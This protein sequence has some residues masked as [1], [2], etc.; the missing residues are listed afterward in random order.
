MLNLPVWSVV[1]VPN[2]VVVC[3]EESIASTLSPVLAVFELL[4]RTC[5]VTIDV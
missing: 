2:G 1:A 3:R 5:P 4:S